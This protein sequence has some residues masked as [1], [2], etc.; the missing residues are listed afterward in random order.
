MSKTELTG[1][2]RLISHFNPKS[3][4]A[5][6]YRQL[7]T[8]IQFSSLDNPVRTL[9]VTSTGPEEGKTTTLANLAVTI[10]Q[11]GSLVTLVDCDLRKPSL[12]DL[13]GLSAEPGLT[14]VLLGSDQ[15]PYQECGIEN[16]RILAAGPLP[17][18]PSEMLG[19]RRMADVIVRLKGEA[20]FVLFDTPPVVIVT[21]AAVLSTRVD[22]AL[23]VVSAGKTRRELA[24]RAKNLLEKVNA[25]L[26]G[27]VL[28][29]VK[30]EPTIHHYYGKK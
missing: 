7:R 30:Y 26:L 1:R 28:N 6:A 19:S 18:N 22:G 14:S 2:D 9:L 27:V 8:N 3:P 29:N 11:T 12:H 4:I 15:I 25:P 10:A 23:L 13:F 5:E 21:D 24:Q 17:P 16:F 20:D